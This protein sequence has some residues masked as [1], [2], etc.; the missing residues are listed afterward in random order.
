MKK[1]LLALIAVSAIVFGLTFYWH[2]Q[3]TPMDFQFSP[4][5]RSACIPPNSY[6]S[7][8]VWFI[9]FFAPDSVHMSEHTDVDDFVTTIA[10]P[11]NTFLKIGSGLAWSPYWNAR[12]YARAHP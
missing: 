8:N 7:I 2:Y 12:K 5:G 6:K 1:V 10:G 3:I 11:D 9:R 4:T